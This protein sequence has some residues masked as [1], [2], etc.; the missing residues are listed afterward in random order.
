MLAILV[1]RAVGDQRGVDAVL[2]QIERQMQA[3]DA[4]AD[5]SDVPCHVASPWLFGTFGCLPLL[6]EPS[7][8]L[9]WRTTEWIGYDLFLMG[10][11]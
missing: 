4:G 6:A 1:R 2:L 5:D 9:A 3:G 8:R 11:N 7:A 10:M